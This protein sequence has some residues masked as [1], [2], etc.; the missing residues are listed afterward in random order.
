MSLGLSPRRLQGAEDRGWAA[1]EALATGGQEHGARGS[2]LWARVEQG[3][4][5]CSR[6]WAPSESPA[7]LDQREG[8]AQVP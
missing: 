4:S 8:S 7:A 3:P 2:R 6:R 1:A 5:D